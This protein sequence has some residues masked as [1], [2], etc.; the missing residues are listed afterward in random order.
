[1]PAKLVDGFGAW[2]KAEVNPTATEN[3]DRLRPNPLVVEATKDA[4]SVFDELDRHMTD[5]KRRVRLSGGDQG[6][7]TRVL[8]TAW[9]LALIRACG[10]RVD[11]PE[12]TEADA[13][14]GADL[15]W[16][17]TEEFLKAV[18]E[19]VAEN[20]IESETQRV[21]AM[22]KEGGR[23]FHRDL[24]RKTQ[25]LDNPRRNGCLATLIEAGMIEKEVIGKTCFYK[26]AE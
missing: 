9:K 24:T 8:A 25:W 1:V 3:L 13:R 22:I 6:P 20:R 19:N 11:K 4:R 10:V 2:L 12:I 16:L 21:F 7:Y 5:V 17:L 14:W 15:A 18:G 23:I 26:P